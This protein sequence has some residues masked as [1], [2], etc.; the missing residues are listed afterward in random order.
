[1][2]PFYIIIITL[3]L[4]SLSFSQDS[5]WQYGY[6]FGANLSSFTGENPYR[7]EAYSNFGLNFGM[8]FKYM[9]ST[10][11]SIY[12]E[13]RYINKGAQWSCTWIS[14]VACDGGST[15]YDMTYLELPLYYSATVIRF[16][17][18][19]ELLTLQ[20]GPFI[21][22]A[23]FHKFSDI[24]EAPGDWVSPNAG[25]EF[26]DYINRF[27]YGISLGAQLFHNK[28]HNFFLRFVIDVSLSPLFK[29]DFR[30]E[31]GDSKNTIKSF[32]LFFGIET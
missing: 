5:T 27:D 25:R 24:N 13:L 18:S 20:I 12:F 23:L 3:L 4:V 6:Q 19:A 2:K 21:S 29:E 8:Y 9:V 1:M 17:D 14:L 31:S 30:L 28:N 26:E 7:G 32:I 15:S 22:Y 16:E 10:F 11:S